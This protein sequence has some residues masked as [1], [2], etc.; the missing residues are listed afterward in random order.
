MRNLVLVLVER[1]TTSYC[2]RLQR[3]SFPFFAAQTSNALILL[4]PLHSNV[5]LRH[6]CFLLAQAIL[7][8]IPMQP[9]YRRRIC[10]RDRTSWC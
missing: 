1:G 9:I 4:P 10:A 5:G 6:F 8:S 2:F 7:H 3:C